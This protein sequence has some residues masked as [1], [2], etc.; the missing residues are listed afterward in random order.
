MGGG[1]LQRTAGAAQAGWLSGVRLKQS[2][3]LGSRGEVQA[4]G[5]RGRRLRRMRGGVIENWGR[6][7][8]GGGG[9]CKQP[10]SRRGKNFAIIAKFMPDTIIYPAK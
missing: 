4:R 5:S 10:K 9:G 2:A 3:W 7:G 1:E 6:G 8:G